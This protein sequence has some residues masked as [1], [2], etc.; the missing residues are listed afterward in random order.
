MSHKDDKLKIVIEAREKYPESSLTELAEI[1]T[2][3]YNYKI[4]KSGV[5]HHFIKI[6]NMVNN[7]KKN[8]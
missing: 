6:S 1:I 8:N 7:H 4:G 5:N 2:S 3:E